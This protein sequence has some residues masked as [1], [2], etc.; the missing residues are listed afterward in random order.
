MTAFATKLF[1]VQSQR[2]L[3]DPIVAIE[4]QGDRIR[5]L[6]KETSRKKKSVKRRAIITSPETASHSLHWALCDFYLESVDLPPLFCLRSKPGKRQPRSKVETEERQANIK[7]A[8]STLQDLL[9]NETTLVVELSTRL[10]L[11]KLLIKYTKDWQLADDNLRMVVS[12]SWKDCYPNSKCASNFVSKL[13]KIS[14]ADRSHDRLGFEAITLRCQLL[15]KRGDPNS[16]T[17]AV[18]LL[19]A[20]TQQ[21]KS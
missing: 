11:A 14:S 15:V 16:I 10:V 6:M 13:R 21:A 5:V 9:I 2:L 8:I 19:S 3:F 18:K 1:D 17:G 7:F 12:L 20:A 4:S